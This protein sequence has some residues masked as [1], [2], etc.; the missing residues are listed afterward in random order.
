MPILLTGAGG[1]QLSQ[2]AQ[3]TEGNYRYKLFV[4]VATIPDLRIGFMDNEAACAALA[5]GA[6]DNNTALIL[7]YNL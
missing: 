1:V 3:G 2:L 7:F 6:S 4:K 5:E